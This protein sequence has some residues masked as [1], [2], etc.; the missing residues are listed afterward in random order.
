MLCSGQLSSAYQTRRL[1]AVRTTNN[2]I[3]SVRLGTYNLLRQS[4]F[5]QSAYEKIGTPNQASGHE[6]LHLD[7]DGL[8]GNHRATPAQRPVPG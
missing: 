8:A 6:Q 7:P 3:S 5:R 2:S 1:E 4:C